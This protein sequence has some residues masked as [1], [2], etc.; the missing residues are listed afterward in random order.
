MTKQQSLKDFSVLIWQI[1]LF[2]V[3]LGPSLSS[4][5][6][7]PIWVIFY[8]TPYLALFYFLIW[9]HYFKTN[10]CTEIAPTNLFV[11]FKREGRVR[12]VGRLVK[13]DNTFSLF[14][15][16]PVIALRN[17]IFLGPVSC[18][19]TTHYIFWPNKYF[20]TQTIFCPKLIVCNNYK[21][22]Q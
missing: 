1:N 10:S 8:F 20:K 18:N 13:Y 3:F 19:P 14:F 7:K 9:A 15:I 2:S 4:P 17:W 21:K 5:N 16:S 6:W 22:P 11:F 12:W